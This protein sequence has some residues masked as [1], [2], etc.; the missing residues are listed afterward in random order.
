MVSD[1]SRTT[2]LTSLHLFI[3][4]LE[5]VVFQ[6]K[7]LR[8]ELKSPV[9]IPMYSFFFIDPPQ[10]TMS[11]AGTTLET[12]PTEVLILIL[13]ALPEFVTI[14]ESRGVPY[15]SRPSTLASRYHS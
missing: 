10:R 8:V 7:N 6:R 9:N 2:L 11:D 14:H 5:V 15:P 1:I 4:S 3:P 12:L 13:K